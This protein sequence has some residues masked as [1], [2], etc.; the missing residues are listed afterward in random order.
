MLRINKLSQLPKG[1]KILIGIAKISIIISITIC[2]V[3]FIFAYYDEGAYHVLG[4]VPDIVLRIITRY[5]DN[6]PL[7]LGG[8]AYLLMLILHFV[9]TFLLLCFSVVIVRIFLKNTRKS[10]LIV[11]AIISIIL[12]LM[13]DVA[14]ISSNYNEDKMF[15]L[16]DGDFG[17]KVPFRLTAV[18]QAKVVKKLGE[19]QGHN[20]IIE[21][22]AVNLHETIF[23][24]SEEYEDVPFNLGSLWLEQYEFQRLSEYLTIDKHG[25]V[26]SH[27]NG[28][29]T[30]LTGVTKYTSC[31]ESGHIEIK[32]GKIYE[33]RSQGL[34]WSKS[35]YSSP[36]T[37]STI[38]INNNGNYY[39]V[40]GVYLGYVPAVNRGI[41]DIIFLTIPYLFLCF[42]IV[43]CVLLWYRGLVF[44]FNK[45][46]P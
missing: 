9:C 1:K 17:L 26:Y 40:Y 29:S 36:S 37:C 18:S 39:I 14:K 28:I 27:R 25:R 24:K 32:K 21:R 11:I 4:G 43:V 10:T 12:A 41:S 45:L 22:N 7:D 19:L 15:V 6:G 42:L 30:V 38:A 13:L 3:D 44:I 23:I 20:I 46:F 33:S 8:F 5:Y 2:L 31:K 16:R 34:Y 35:R